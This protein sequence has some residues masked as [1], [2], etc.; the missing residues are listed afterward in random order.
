M[1]LLSSCQTSPEV[2]TEIETVV[3]PLTFPTPPDP[4]GFVEVDN[5][6]GDVIVQVEWWVMLAEY[7]E[8]VDATRKQYEL[9]QRTY[10]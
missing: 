2:V 1:L 5:T 7:M 3:P 10:D 4:Q 8:D 9:Y 6:T